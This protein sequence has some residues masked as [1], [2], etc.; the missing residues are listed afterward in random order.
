MAALAVPAP[1][2]V[3]VTTA[4]ISGI[5]LEQFSVSWATV[6]QVQ[7]PAERLSRVSSYDV[8]GSYI[9]IPVAYA[10][11]GP[12]STAIGVDMTMWGAVALV[13]VTTLVVVASREVRMMSSR[14]N[15]DCSEGMEGEM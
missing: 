3:I 2:V 1:L 5:G 13:L 4:A 10:V 9:F 11:V 7:I 12:I 6:L 14:G 15:Y 8:L